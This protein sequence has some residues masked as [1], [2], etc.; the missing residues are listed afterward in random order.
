MRHMPNILLLLATLL[1]F[2][3]LS[4]CDFSDKGET[5]AIEGNVK[6]S[7]IAGGCWFIQSPD[8]RRYEP[9]DM[10]EELKEEDLF[11]NLIVRPRDD[12]ASIC[13]IGRLVEIVSVVEA[14]K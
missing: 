7:A 6:F 4:S 14:G 9:I 8:D 2:C 10:P 12:A 1:L 3:L 13:M 11:V 5:F